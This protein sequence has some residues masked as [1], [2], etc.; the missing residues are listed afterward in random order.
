MQATRTSF[1]PVQIGI[2]VLTLATAFIH[3]YLNVIMGKLD[4]LFTLNGLGYLAFLAAMFLPLP[5]IKENRSLV[6]MAFIVYTLMTIVAWVVMGSRDLLGFST[7]AIEVALVALLWLDRG[8][9]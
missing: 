3:F 7:K 4:I 9:R 1:G 2:V 5:F 6:R 8:R